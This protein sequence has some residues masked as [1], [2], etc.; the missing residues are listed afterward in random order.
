MSVLR[1]VRAFAGQLLLLA[2]LAGLT[3][4]LVAGP[5][6]LANGRTDDGLRGDIGR[7]AYT[8]RDLTL[9]A[10]QR[11]YEP[12]RAAGAGELAALRQ[13]LPAPLT[14]MIGGSWYIA[15]S[16]RASVVPAGTTAGSCPNAATIRYEPAAAAA[17]T[18][19]AGRQPD[20]TRIP[21]VMLGEHEAQALRI[22]LGD[23]LDLTSRW[24][25]GRVQVVGLYRAND[26]ADPIWDDL[27]LVPNV[28][29]PDPR[30]GTRSLAVLLGDQTAAAEAG[31]LVGDFGDRWRFRLDERR[32]TADRVDALA[33]AV[34]RLRHNPPPE[35]TLQSSLDS[36]L[37]AF[38][39]QVRA[40]RAL[41]AVVQAGILATAAGLILLAA[42]LMAG[43]RRAEFALIRARGGAVH[44]VAGRTVL[45]TLVVVPAAVALGW[46]GGAL[47]SGRP[48][49]AEPYLVVAVLL[50]GLL[51]A[52]AY[53]AFDAR[54]PS[55]SGHRGDV[56]ALRPPTRR[57]T[58][59]GF[60]V[61][62]AVG[63]ILLLR[64]RGL[65]AGAG[66]DP[67][68]IGTPVLLALAASVVALR[69][70]PF[71]LRWAGRIAARARGAI[72]FLGLSGAGRAPM[73]SG[74]LAVLVV[75]I[76]TGLFT[77]TVT[78]TVGG[79]R[80]RAAD[81]SVPADALVTGFA[82]TPDTAARLAAL[83]HVTRVTPV[84]L[85]PGTTI[86]GDTSPMIL[87]GQAMVVDAA[88][89][90]LDLPAALVAAKPGTAA[91]P[92]AVSPHLA[93]R[94][95]TAG[96]VDVQGRRYRYAVAAIVATVP[97]LGTDTQDFMVLPEQAMPIPDFAPIVPNRLLVDGAGLDVA[98]L[99][100]TADAGQVDQLR[101]VTGRAVQAW[102]LA[103]PATVTTR[104]A[105]RRS[106]EQRGVDGALSFTFTAGMVAAAALSLTAVALAVLTGAP[107]RGRTLSRL[108]TMGLSRR[109]GRRL[110][111][112]EL[113]PLVAVAVLAGGLAGFT[114]PALIGPALGLD[115]FTAGVT[116]G[117]SLDPWFA[118]GV[119]AL[120]VVAVIAA[121]AVENVANRRL[122][123][124]SVLRLGEEQS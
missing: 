6:R 107:A 104:T 13:K 94:I 99:R 11:D 21:E 41:L 92:V 16:G 84:L 31:N 74:P 53:A 55:F 90:G 71:P 56:A 12:S 108:R 37:A 88:A 29:C 39:R 98:R 18:M 43:R 34:A 14:G 44:T 48:D 52:P 15:E 60:L 28:A 73:H 122:R 36:T 33:S 103:V 81:L 35:T 54:R 5:V 17:I 51:A 76:A 47:V 105:Y 72:A 65:D 49:P 77:G 59:E 23:R 113:V 38:D 79:A 27:K 8:S 96:S 114:L 102:E 2:V 106:L 1:R 50:V 62:L 117:I 58:A 95:G 4:F 100:D 45:E 121:L 32:I 120:A 86:H 7:L 97:G 89:A 26:P 111:V 82:F 91:I 109:Q 75:A 61:L 25:T 40:V 30:D 46:L 68:L 116:A 70:V 80:D 10:I 123:V 83:P 93:E 64:R 118:G 3:A 78:S 115:G 119:L 66:V 87:Q 67:Y 101:K 9:S 57:L 85:A 112:F 22:R 124:G 69:L 42:R 24:G 20:T 63:G 19:V 110:L